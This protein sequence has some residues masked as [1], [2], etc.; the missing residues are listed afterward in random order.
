MGGPGSGNRWR[1]DARSTTDDYRTLDVRRWA[2]AGVLRP[3]Y[4]GGW[5][6]TRHGE[7]IASIRMRAE[8]GRVI[9]QYR[10]RNAG[11]DWADVEYPVLIERTAC[12][13]GGSRPW[14]IC[15]GRGCGRRVAILYGGNV[16]ACRHCH[17]LAYAST[18]EDVCD[19]LA[20]RAERIRERLGWRAGFLNP[21]GSKPKWMRWA[22]YRRLREE[23]NHLVHGAL[24]ALAVNSGTLDL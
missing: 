1:Y 13:V 8:P 19:R 18:R 11:S 24:S 9:L 15:P 23:H 20:R 7:V 2:R 17:R 21:P 12:H 4:R 10:C 16:F 3:G 6:W 5:Q 14:F 22:T